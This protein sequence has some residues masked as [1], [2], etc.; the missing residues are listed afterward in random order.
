MKIITR[1]PI[2]TGNVN[3]FENDFVSN[4]SDFN[5]MT[6]R[7]TEADP[8]MTGSLDEFEDDFVSN[9]SGFN[10]VTVMTTDPILTDSDY[11][12]DDWTSAASGSTRRA[13]KSAR[14]S[15]R[16]KR[17]ATG[18][19]LI[20]RVGK[21]LG[22]I[23]DSGIVDTLLNARQGAGNYDPTYDPNLMIP[24]VVTDEDKGMSTGAKVAIG[25]LILAVV[26]GGA[27]YFLNKKK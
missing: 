21:G 17:R 5:G 6:V 2:I 9:N 27:Y 20:N 14:Q 10:G 18:D 15:T 23:A 3:T 24:P 13:K 16:Q 19:T 25:I 26:G 8:I 1:N 7:T 4:K 22:K 12:E 11:Y